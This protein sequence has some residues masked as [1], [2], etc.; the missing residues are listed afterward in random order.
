MGWLRKSTNF[1]QSLVEI[2]IAMGLS[3]LILP[4]VYL[5]LISVRE[6]KAVQVQ[7]AVASDQ[8]RELVE[9]VRQVREHGWAYFAV[10]GVFHPE[11]SA[12]AWTLVPGVQ[13]L[14]G[15]TRS[16]TVSPAY[17]DNTTGQIAPESASSHLDPS[18][19]LAVFTVSWTTPFTSSVSST[20][21]LTR[22]LDN[23]TYIETTY[24]QFDAGTKSGT[25]VNYTGG[26]PTDGEITLGGGGH[27][28]WCTPDLTLA[29]VDLPK[30][31]VANALTAIPATSE[32]PG[33]AFAGTGD[34]AS[35]VS[36]AK[37]NITDADPPAASI[38]T[39]GTYDPGGN[40]KTNGVFGEADYAYLSTD[41]NTKEIEIINLQTNPYS[42]S[43]YFDA[44]GNG[45][46][47]GIWVS[48]SVGYMTSSNKFYT[49]DLSSK[50]GNRGLPLNNAHVV[51]LAGTGVKI[52]VNGT[53]AYVAVN[54]VAT[55][56]QIIDISNP[57]FPV[58]VG[59]ANNLNDQG[60]T[61]IFVNDTATRAY[62]VTANSAASPELFIL[63]IE[64]KTGNH[65]SLASYDSGAMSPKGVIAVT[66]NKVILVGTGGTE[67]Q[68][69]NYDDSSHVISSCPNGSG[70]LNVDTGINDIDAVVQPSGNAF[71]YIITGDAGTEFK[72]IRGGP[73]GQL[74][75][76]GTFES[77]AYDVLASTAFNRMISTASLPS[78]TDIHFQVAIADPVSGSCSG[79]N[80]VFRDIDF[81]GIIPL[82]DDGLGYENP[83]Q[84]LKYRVT[85]TTSSISISPVLYDV[86]FNYSP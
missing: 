11:I 74:A 76:T 44:P 3:A 35:G 9:S 62:V 61:G 16:I 56:V 19:K 22:Y 42:E 26:S 79:A 51:T 4:A 66:N 40:M 69:V 37:V 65:T 24:A 71:S 81:T 72:V 43:G 21:Y 14:D 29:Q 60:A 12:G 73:S 68:V 25:S 36:F 63:N 15:Y 45:N 13:T 38:P 49:F 67:Y 48:G 50:S 57:A 47:N 59:Q 5:G 54:S 46:G 34:N 2:I 27:G 70:L 6:G 41:N 23:L 53:Y 28:D 78:G 85:L 77:S 17:R 75:T 20:A 30:S 82:D 84:C 18:T 52:R 39:P 80:Y 7:R 58:I 64:T 10:D 86:T 1:G 32:N 83:G 8:L 31:G 33:Y 55:Q